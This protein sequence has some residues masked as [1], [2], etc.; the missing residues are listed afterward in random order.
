M[1]FCKIMDVKIKDYIKVYTDC[2]SDKDKDIG[3]FGVHIPELDFNFSS[4]RVHEN[5]NIYSIEMLAIIMPPLL[6]LKT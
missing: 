5:L 2:S 1:G 3:G 6:F 4:I